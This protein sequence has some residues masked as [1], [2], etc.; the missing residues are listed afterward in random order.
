MVAHASTI[1]YYLKVCHLLQLVLS[2]CLPF[3]HQVLSLANSADNP[4]ETPLSTW[5]AELF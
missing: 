1:D 4:S 5:K 2:N 3:P